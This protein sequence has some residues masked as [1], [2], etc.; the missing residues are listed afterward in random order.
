MKISSSLQV[1]EFSKNFLNFFVGQE[2]MWIESFELFL[3]GKYYGSLLLL[4]P[5]IEHALRKLYLSD[6]NCPSK[7]GKFV[8]MATK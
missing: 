3:Q 2:S 5:L 7:R 1:K 4:F 8:V 6:N